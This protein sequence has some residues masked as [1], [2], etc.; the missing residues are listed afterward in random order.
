MLKQGDEK[1]I[2]VTDKVIGKNEKPDEELAFGVERRVK[3]DLS[4]D[5]A[6][7]LVNSFGEDY[8]VRVKYR[9]IGLAD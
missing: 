7:A 5:V 6:N 4:Q 1:I 9:L 3:I 2:A 8:D